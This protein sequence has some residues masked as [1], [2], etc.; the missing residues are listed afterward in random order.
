MILLAESADRQLD[1]ARDG[2]AVALM[3][4]NRR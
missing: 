2:L 3:P 1:L 4:K